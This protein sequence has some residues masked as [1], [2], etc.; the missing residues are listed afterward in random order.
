MSARVRG[1]RCNA[2]RAK[3]RRQALTADD[4][5]ARL[6]DKRASVLGALQDLAGLGQVTCHRDDGTWSVTQ[7]GRDFDEDTTPGGTGPPPK[8][9]GTS[10]LRGMSHLR[11]KPYRLA[12]EELRRA[13]LTED[14][15]A[16][17]LGASEGLVLKTLSILVDVGHVEER[18]DGMWEI[19]DAGAEF[20]EAK[21]PPQ[22]RVRFGPWHPP[23]TC[24]GAGGPP[25]SP[26]EAHSL[27][28]RRALSGLVYRPG[29]PSL[30]TSISAAR[31]GVLP[32]P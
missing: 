8:V 26:G 29:R 17:L 18:A 2:I 25:G 5:A 21:P 11:E 15:L 14:D 19:T 27:C 4:L 12:R 7:A 1:W 28:R 30:R 13:A 6:D 9:R 31:E 32:R 10:R 23:D 20:A 16:C 24:L 3:L 22:G